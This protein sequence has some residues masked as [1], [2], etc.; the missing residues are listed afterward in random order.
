MP[1]KR[2]LVKARRSE[3]PGVH[4]ME[5]VDWLLLGRLRNHDELPEHLRDSY[6]QFVEFDIGWPPAALD[7]MWRTHRSALMAEARRRG[8]E[9]PWG[10]RFDCDS[11]VDR[12]R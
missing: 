9:K 4:Q 10:L 12:R 6:D 2:R 7:E 5:I 11:Q 1:R 8:I 3:M